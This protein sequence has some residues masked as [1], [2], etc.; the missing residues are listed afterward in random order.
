MAKPQLRE[1]IAPDRTA[2]VL[3]ELQNGV[4]GGDVA[5]PALAEAA[6]NVGVIPNATRLVAAARAV[7]VTVVH[8]TAETLA[9]GFGANHNARLFASAQKA[10]ADIAAGTPAV[11][12][13]AAL[14]AA[15]DIVLPRFHGLSPLTGGPLDSLLRNAGITSIVVAGVSLNVAIPN[16][17][18]DAINRSFRV[19]VITDAVAGTPVSY[20]EQVIEHCLSFLATLA[21]T[22]ELVEAWG[23]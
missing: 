3:Q 15:G 23:H 18:F 22:N 8:A 2:I 7:G 19:V 4:V 5:F 10:G 14:Y 12:P 20:G 6:A 16:L 11:Q 17:V 1:L 21:T 13:V 9:H